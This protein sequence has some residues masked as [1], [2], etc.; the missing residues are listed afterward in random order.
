MAWD[1]ASTVRV[2]MVDPSAGGDDL[3]VESIPVR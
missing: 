2:A 1:D 3:I